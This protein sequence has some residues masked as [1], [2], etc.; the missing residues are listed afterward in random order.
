[1]TPYNPG[2]QLG[3]DVVA[4][5]RCHPL[6]PPGGDLTELARVGRLGADHVVDQFVPSLP[7]PRGPL[8]SSAGDAAAISSKVAQAAVTRSARRRAAAEVT[9]AR[10]AWTVTAGTGRR[11]P[12]PQQPAEGLPGPRSTHWKRLQTWHLI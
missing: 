8:R 3:H 6:R 11:H 7:P 4:V 5:A 1:M 9:V 10:S 12:L 2:L